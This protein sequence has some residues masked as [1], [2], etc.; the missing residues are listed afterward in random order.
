MGMGAV[1]GPPAF[2]SVP[3]SS[4]AGVGGLE[5]SEGVLEVGEDVLG[6]VA[7][8]LGG[9]EGDLGVPGSGLVLGRG[10]VSYC[11]TVGAKIRPAA[12]LF[13]LPAKES[14]SA[15]IRAAH[16]HANIAHPDFR[17]QNGPCLLSLRSGRSHTH[18]GLPSSD[19]SSASKP[20]SS[21]SNASS[22]S[23]TNSGE[24]SS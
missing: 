5:A 7:G 17:H 1:A 13:L 3:E 12:C 21:A 20:D 22:M 11:S 14:A 15:T 19:S 8:V 6:G 9:V 24:G 2:I 16:M 18:V 4:G 10:P 23:A